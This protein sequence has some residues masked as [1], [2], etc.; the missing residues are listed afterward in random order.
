MK[1]SEFRVWFANLFRLSR[2]QREEVEQ[3]LGHAKSQPPLAWPRTETIIDP[4]PAIKG[5]A[6]SF[7]CGA[8][9]ETAHGGEVCC[10]RCQAPKP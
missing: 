7:R 8:W 3:A 4:H 9:L 6:G 10:P 1:M 2:S 5:R